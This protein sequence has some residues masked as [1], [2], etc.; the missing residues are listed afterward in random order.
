MLLMPA[1][2]A[3]LVQGG[4]MLTEARPLL[5]AAGGGLF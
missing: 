4:P 5:T 1:G 2:T 3:L